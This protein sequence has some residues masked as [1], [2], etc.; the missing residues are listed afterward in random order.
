[1]LCTTV[2]L[3][4]FKLALRVSCNLL[5]NICCRSCG[6]FMFT[7]HTIKCFRRGANAENMTYFSVCLKSARRAKALLMPSNLARWE[8]GGV[9]F[10]PL[11][12]S[13]VKP[14]THIILCKKTHRVWQSIINER[15]GT[16]P[17]STKLWLA[18][19]FP[20]MG[21]TSN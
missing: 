3:C 14:R 11:I 17:R 21:E 1:M 8:Q 18:P 4:I 7:Q 16:I 10:Y 13:D 12:Q 6:F 5:F 15:C 2:Q 9:F 20:A 19:F